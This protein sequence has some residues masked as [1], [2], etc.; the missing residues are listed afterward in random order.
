MEKS[1]GAGQQVGRRDPDL[2]EDDVRVLHDAQ[3]DLVGDLRCGVA[4]TVRLHDEALDVL[5]SDVPGPNEGEV[6]DGAGADPALGAVEDPL[7]AVQPRGGFQ[8]AG[9]VRAVVRLGQGERPELGERGEAREPARLLFLRAELVDHADDQLV[10]DPDERREGHVGAGHLDI[11]E[12][13]EELGRAVRLQPAQTVFAEFGEQPEGK[14][15]AVPVVDRCGPDPG[16]QEF[17]DLLVAELFVRRQQVHD[18]H[19]VGVGKRRLP[20]LAAAV[21]V[22]LSLIPPCLIPLCFRFCLL[23]YLIRLCLPLCFRLAPTV[24]WHVLVAARARIPSSCNACRAAPLFQTLG[25]PSILHSD[26]DH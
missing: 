4:R 13:L 17:P 10:V 26:G 11:H 2:V 20:R 19:E 3:A 12:P 1:G 15:L 22:R 25:C 14:L 23:L 5:V 24:R 21:A 9:D 6:R 8:A 7:V 16:L 18:V